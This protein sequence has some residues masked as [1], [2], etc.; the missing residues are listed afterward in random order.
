MAV[1]A[2]PEA[3]W[4]VVVFQEAV[5]D[6][7]EAA[8]AEAAVAEEAVAASVVPVISEEVLADII[9]DQDRFIFIRAMAGKR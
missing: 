4:A 9:T 8:L 3:E 5:S 6:A 7:A 2:F 1:E